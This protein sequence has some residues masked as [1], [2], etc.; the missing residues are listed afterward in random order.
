MLNHDEWVL[1]GWRNDNGQSLGPVVTESKC[2]VPSFGAPVSKGR[3]DKAT[4]A[5]ELRRAQPTAGASMASRP[6]ACSLR[7]LTAI[8]DQVGSG[9]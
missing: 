1:V 8:R 4:R 7:P 2:S 9:G 5:K 6:C 3:L